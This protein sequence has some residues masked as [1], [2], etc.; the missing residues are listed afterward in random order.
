MTGPAPPNRLRD[1]LRL[2]LG[3]L[4]AFP[5]PPPV[6]VDRRTAAVGIALAWLPG[7]LLGVVA[8]AAAAAA[9]VL[10]L[11]VLVVAAL[12]IAVL[13]LCCRGFHLD[14]LGDTADGLAAGP[15]RERMLRVMRS[16]DSGPAAVATTVLVLLVQVGCLA[17]VV[18]RPWWQAAAAVVVVVALSRA[19]LVLPC[20]ASVPAARPEGLGAGVIGVVPIPLAVV[21]VLLTAAAGTAAL[22]AAGWPWWSGPVA[23]LT[24]SAVAALLVRHV[25][26]R[27]GGVNGD[28]LGA[29]VEVAFTALLLVLAA[30]T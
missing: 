29:C 3:T 16:G 20:A 11:P 10:T 13:Q 19:L 28:S 2:S 9:A 25:T 5:T 27:L 18:E 1:G 14:G 6:L 15:D 23:V 8:A 21:V 17:V 12:S 22:T 30:A 7:L 26:S 4:T 24:A